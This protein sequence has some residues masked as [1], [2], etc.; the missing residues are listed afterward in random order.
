MK[1]RPEEFAG[2]GGVR[3]STGPTT[4]H[5]HVTGTGRVTDAGHRN[6]RTE[7]HKFRLVRCV[8]ASSSRAQQA[9]LGIFYFI[10]E[11]DSETFYD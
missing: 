4:Q 9:T 7:G 2:L 10:H 8:K 6:R 5:L 1:L 11:F 3:K